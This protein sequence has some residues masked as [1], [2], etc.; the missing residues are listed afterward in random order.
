MKREQGYP[1]GVA[2]LGRMTPEYAEILTLDALNFIAN[3]G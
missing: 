1:E 2:V 3:T